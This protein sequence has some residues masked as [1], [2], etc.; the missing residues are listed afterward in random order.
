VI[1]DTNGALTDETAV[2]L[3]N[4]IQEPQ[5]AW[6]VTAQMMEDGTFKIGVQGEPNLGEMHMLLA[7]AMESVRCR[8]VAETVLHIQAQNKSSIITPEQFGA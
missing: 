5:P 7:R 3:G 8:M 2:D 6:G 4:D 1:D